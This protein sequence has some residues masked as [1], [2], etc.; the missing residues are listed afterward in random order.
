MV[1]LFQAGIWRRAYERHQ[2][3]LGKAVAS[4]AAEA[5]DEKL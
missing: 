3:A 5:A 4:A 1:V 2:A